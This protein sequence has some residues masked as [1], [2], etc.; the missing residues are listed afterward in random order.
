V[1]PREKGCDGSSSPAEAGGDLIYWI[2]RPK[3]QKSKGVGLALLPGTVSCTDVMAVPDANELP[4]L[5]QH[6]VLRLENG[7]VFVVGLVEGGSW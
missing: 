6:W 4:P 7:I 5:F 1:S 3:K 2:V